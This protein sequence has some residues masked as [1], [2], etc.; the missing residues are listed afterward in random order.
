M[1]CHES[2]KFYNA[3]IRLSFG[4]LVELDDKG[5]ITNF[6]SYIKQIPKT[7]SS[8]FIDQKWTDVFVPVDERYR[9]FDLSVLFEEAGAKPC[10]ILTVYNE[11][12]YIEWKFLRLK[13]AGPDQDFSGILGAG[14]DVTQH[15]E[16]K[17]QLHHADR[18]AT[19]GQLAAGIAHEINGPLNNILGYAQLSA[20][21]QDLP[22]QVYNDLDNIVRLSLHAREVVKKVM[23]FSRQVPPKHDLV[24]LNKV[25]RESLYFT[26]PLC[27]QNKITIENRLDEKLPQIVGD[28][29][30]L[31]QVVVNLIVNSA[32]AMPEDGGKII[33]ETDHKG[34]E[35]VT[36]VV[37]DTGLGMSPRVLKQCFMPFFTTKDVD[38]GTGL[39]LSVVHGI[40][41][42]HNA[43]IHV[44]SLVNKGS[45][46][47]VVFPPAM[48]NG[49]KNA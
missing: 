33:V 43:E 1:I 35:D 9:E 15:I 17:Q 48:E 7:A 21:Q 39:G 24:D 13:D 5:V 18:L 32:Q 26:E 6:N 49:D 10:K 4:C 38:E 23:L 30:Q 37:R 11:T 16:L 8:R 44:E 29:S 28:F 46:F 2:S 3:A 34:A 45:T 25:I 31:R 47:M 20:K 41:K 19:V 36:M 22:E 14:I 27:R 12:L 40:I 42:A